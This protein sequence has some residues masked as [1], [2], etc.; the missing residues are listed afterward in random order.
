MIGRLA[1]LRR[2]PV[3]GQS[4]YFIGTIKT[5]RL[6]AIPPAA[7]RFPSLGGATDA[8][9]LR[10]HATIDAPSRGRGV[11]CTRPPDTPP[12]CPWK[13]PDLPSSRRNPCRRAHAPTT[14]EE[15][16]GTRLCAPSD[17]ATA[18]GTTGAS[19]TDFRGSIAWPDDSLS[20]LRRGGRPTRRKTRFRL[21]GC[22]LPGGAYTHW[23][24][25]G[26]VSAMCPNHISFSFRELAWRNPV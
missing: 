4:P 22:P 19:S 11:C 12:N 3:D 16:N 1:S 21:R 24:S 2:V 15:P 25:Q 20:T 8:S 17:A 10:S 5:L 18:T 7:L 9:R 13:G 6:P 26:K 14:P 23:V